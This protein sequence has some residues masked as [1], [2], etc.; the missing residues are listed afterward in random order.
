MAEVDF[1]YQNWKDAKFKAIEGWGV[2]Y[3]STTAGKWPPA[4][5]TS[6]IPA[7]AT[8][9]RINYRIGGF[10]ITTTTSLSAAIMCVT[11]GVGRFRFP[12]PSFKTLVNLT[13]EYRHRQAH[14][15]PLVKEQYFNIAIGVNFNEMWFWRNKLR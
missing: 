8:W 13:F 4:Y 7:E 6:P 9:S 10:S 12:V 14:P 3:I 5:S 11:M 2:Y 1:T 15:D